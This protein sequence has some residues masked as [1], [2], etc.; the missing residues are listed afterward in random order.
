MK[1]E[2]LKKKELNKA[3]EHL[4][5]FSLRNIFLNIEDDYEAIKSRFAV[6]D[7][8]TNETVAIVSEDYK[9][10]QFKEVYDAILE[11]FEDYT[12]KVFYF[13]GRSA[14]LVWPIDKDMDEEIGLIVENSVDRSKAI[15]VK[16]TMKYKGTVLVIP[17]QLSG[18]HQIHVG[19]GV[20]MRVED[21]ASLIQNVKTEWKTIVKKFSSYVIEEV[22]EVEDVA[23]EVTK[24]K[25]YIDAVKDEYTA[26]NIRTLWDL[27]VMMVKN[28]DVMRIKSDVQR[29]VFIS[30]IADVV[31]RYAASLK[32]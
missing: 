1:V 6:A 22:K 4:P 29:L 25:K 24:T 32:L 10:V 28:T 27:F 8:D 19:K 5:V 23:A 9:L 11:K 17:K 30:D 20:Q 26:G 7:V 15:T 18:L 2:T 31:Y 16:F 14:M 13:N 3:I 21:Y 12:G